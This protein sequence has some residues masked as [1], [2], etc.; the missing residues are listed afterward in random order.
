[1][2]PCSLVQRYPC[3][4]KPSTSISSAECFVHVGMPGQIHVVIT[5]WHAVFKTDFP[6]RR[7]TGVIVGACAFAELRKANVSFVMSVRLSCME[8]FGSHWTDFHEI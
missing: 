6:K 4:R 3:R 1:M 7:N 5:L 2:T 8:Q